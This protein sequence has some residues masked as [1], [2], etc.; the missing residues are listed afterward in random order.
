LKKKGVGRFRDMNKQGCVPSTTRL[1]TAGNACIDPKSSGERVVYKAT[2][3][4]EKDTLYLT[5]ENHRCI[6]PVYSH[7]II[8]CWYLSRPI[9]S[10]I[11]KVSL[12]GPRK[13]QRRK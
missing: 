10:L 13:R 1:E 5:P 2:A 11:H 3:V 9:I 6:T 12:W 7:P 8:P 4:E